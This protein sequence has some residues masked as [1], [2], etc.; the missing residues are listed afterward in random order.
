MHYYVRKDYRPRPTLSDY[1]RIAFAVLLIATLSVSI[2]AYVQSRKTR[3]LYEQRNVFNLVSVHDNCIVVYDNY[4]LCRRL[5]D[6]VR[7]V[8]INKDSINSVKRYKLE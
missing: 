8:V 7:L 3:I 6:S 2:A 4:D 5:P 1:A